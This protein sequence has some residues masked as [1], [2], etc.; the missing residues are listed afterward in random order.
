MAKVLWLYVKPGFDE[1][2]AWLNVG[3]MMSWD[4]NELA[5]LELLAVSSLSLSLLI[6]LKSLY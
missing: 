3:F 4:E 5:F 2:G 6:D 1:K